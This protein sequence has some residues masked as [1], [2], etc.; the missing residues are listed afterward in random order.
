VGRGDS[1]AFAIKAEFRDRNC[2]E[3]NDPDPKLAIRSRRRQKSLD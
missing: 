3:T 1:L 2:V